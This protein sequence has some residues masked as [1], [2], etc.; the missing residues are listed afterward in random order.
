MVLTERRKNVLVHPRASIAVDAISA[1]ERKAILDGLTALARI[2]LDEWEKHRVH[3]LDEV[4]AH[5][6]LRTPPDLVTFFTLTPEGKFVIEDILR[7]AAL[8][9]FRA[10][11]RNSA[12][13]K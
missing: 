4:P 11:A 13:D 8:E 7:E 2:P 5:F 1:V 12:G 9:Q 6:V 10:T 3:R